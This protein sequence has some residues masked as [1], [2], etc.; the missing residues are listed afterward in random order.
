MIL[1]SLLVV[2]F[3]LLPFVLHRYGLADHR[4][5]RVC[6]A[7]FAV[8]V[9]LDAGWL[10]RHVV[11]VHRRNILTRRQ[12]VIVL[13]IPIP[14]LTIAALLLAANA[15]VVPAELAAAVYLTGIGLLLFLAGFAFSLVI[16]SFLGN[17]DSES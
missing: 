4:V 11:R 9:A 3:S 1:Y 6:S 10:V 13:T 15:T 17:L 2:A 8:A 7:L 12:L 14:T 5:W 16:F